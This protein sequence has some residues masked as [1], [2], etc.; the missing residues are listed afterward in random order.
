[1]SINLCTDYRKDMMWSKLLGNLVAF[2]IIGVNAILK[3]LIIKLIIWI[4][5]DTFSKRLT[6]ITNMVFAAQFFNTGILLLLVNANLSEHTKI[7]GYSLFS[8]GQFYD[9]AP[10][11]YIDVGFKIVQT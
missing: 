6:S 10:Q 3:I 4:G 9:Y 2:F 11:W 7:P 1:M 8:F 5:E